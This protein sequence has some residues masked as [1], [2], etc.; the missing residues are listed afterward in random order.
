MVHLLGTNGVSKIHSDVVLLRSIV[1]IPLL[2]TLFC[3]NL[4]PEMQHCQIEILVC[5]VICK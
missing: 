1:E 5:N 3:S 2:F 4:Q